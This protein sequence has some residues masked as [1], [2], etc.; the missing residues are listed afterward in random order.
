MV[1]GQRGGRG[2]AAEPLPPVAL[3]LAQIGG[4][5]PGDVVAVGTRLRQERLAPAGLAEGLVE[6]EDLGEEDREAPAVEEQV[7]KAPHQEVAG[8][9]GP[10][11]TQAEERLPAKAAKAADAAKIEAARPVGGEALLPAIGELRGGP[12]TAP[13]LDRPRQ[14]DA[15]AHELQRLVHPAPE[16]SGAERRV[17]LDHPLPGMLEGGEVE[18]AVE[19]G[20]QLLEVELRAGGVEAVEEHALL[21][22]S[23][24]IEVFHPA[25]LAALPEQ[26]VEGFL[27]EPGEREVGGRGASR[28]GRQAVRDERPQLGD[29]ALRQPL[30][31][32]L[33]VAAGIVGQAHPQA[34]AEHQ[35]VDREEGTPHRV[36]LRRSLGA[37][38][39]LRSEGEE[40]ACR[41]RRVELAQIV[42]RDLRR[43]EGGEALSDLAV[44]EVAQQPIA[45][46]VARHLAQPLLDR[47]DRPPQIS[48]RR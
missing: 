44:G 27:V 40:A 18:R 23:E 31:R 38:D 30:G 35:G 7:M 17:A 20:G 4:F 6:G 22:R 36:V 47:P 21:Q 32:R 29:E 37:A 45:Q 26:A 5:K 24:R 11:Q 3:G 42:E 46:A 10:H 13:I 14:L 16:E 2:E 8:L 1:E 33:E 19:R 39:R 12:R 9:A 15:P 43:R 41:E 34:I 28:R 48:S 25:L